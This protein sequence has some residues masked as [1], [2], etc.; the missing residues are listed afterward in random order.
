M[1]ISPAV[2]L[3]SIA[4]G[5]GGGA[6]QYLDTDVAVVSGFT[7]SSAKEVQIS[8]GMMQS[9]ILEYSGSGDVAEVFRS[10]IEAMKGQ[11]W[12]I[13]NVDVGGE[14]AVGRLRKDNRTCELEFAKASSKVRAVIKVGTTK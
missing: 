14:R 2:L 5:C 7:Q 11:G 12:T 4:A 6:G 8:A 13:A 9:G 3:L 1:R 10:Y